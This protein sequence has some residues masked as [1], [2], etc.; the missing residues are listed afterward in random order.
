MKPI[1]SLAL[2]AGLL[3]GCATG[4]AP[5]SSPG[6]DPSDP[7]EASNRS[8]LE[9]NTSLDDNV[10]RPAAE[11]YRDNIPAPMRA[12]LRNFLRNLNEPVIFAN[13]ILQ[14][15]LLDA[16]HTLMRFYINSTAGGLGIFDLATPAG[17]ERRTG[18]FGQ[19]LHAWGVPDGP[20]LMLPLL[21]PT[22]VRDAVGDGV[23]A[24]GSPVGLLTSATMSAV[25]AQLFGV[26]RG[27]LGG[28]DLRAENIDT[29]DALR[30]ES[31]DYYSRL[32]SVVRQRRDAE[33]G[34]SSAEG[35][36]LTT[37]DDPGAGAA[38]SVSLSV[39]VVAVA[40]P[41]GNAA[42]TDPAWARQVLEAARP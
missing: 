24:L 34:R 21:G 23:D 3:A 15:R 31:L 27:A 25:T 7:F 42:R 9:F 32:R 37:L 29:L 18:D 22:T 33:L 4:G 1:L 28:L 40:P 41:A 11:A 6:G 30:G 12:G 17:I 2:L 10:L 8:V 16:G 26:G 35:E 13:N 39:P 5:G 20:Y 36:G 19:T 14:L 38:P